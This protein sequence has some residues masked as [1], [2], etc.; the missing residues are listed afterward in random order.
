MKKILLILILISPLSALRWRVV[1]EDH[2]DN[3][4]IMHVGLG[5]VVSFY[6]FMD[7][8]HNYNGNAWLGNWKA[9]PYKGITI[10]D[11]GAYSITLTTLVGFAY[12]VANGFMEKRGDGFSW[13]DFV[14]DVGGAL[15]GTASASIVSY[16]WAKHKGG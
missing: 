12:E 7:T 3:T 6:T 2:W 9:R 4:S 15:L 14:C 11:A 16:L 5:Y 1:H 8:R 13:R 10:V